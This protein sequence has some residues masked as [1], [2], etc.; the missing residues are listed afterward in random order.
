MSAGVRERVEELRRLIDHHSRRYYVLDDPE[1]GDDEYDALFRELQQ[2]EEAHPELQSPESPRRLAAPC[3]KVLPVAP[4]SS[5]KPPTSR[6]KASTLNPAFC[7]CAGR[8]A[9]T[10]STTSPD[11]AQALRN[12]RPLMEISPA[13]L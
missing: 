7:A 8:P 13:A 4:G 5:V 9:M 3:T 11:V 1:I 12:C 10:P 6:R 2:L